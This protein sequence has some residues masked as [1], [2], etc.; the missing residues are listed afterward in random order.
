MEHLEAALA[1]AG[2]RRPDL[3]LALLADRLADPADELAERF[4]QTSAR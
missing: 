3:V 2:R 1:E 4:Q